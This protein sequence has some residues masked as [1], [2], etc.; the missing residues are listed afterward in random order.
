MLRRIAQRNLI[1]EPDLAFETCENQ[2]ELVNSQGF[3]HRAQ[4][5]L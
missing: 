4:L 2:A 1:I 3:D 5:E